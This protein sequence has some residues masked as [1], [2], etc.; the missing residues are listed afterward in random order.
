MTPFLLTLLV[1]LL[2]AGGLTL[3]YRDYRPR[4][5]RAV[6]LTV[7]TG[8]I[9]ASYVMWVSGGELKRIDASQVS[10]SGLR[11]IETAGSFRLEGQ[12]HNHSTTHRISTLPVRL[13]VEDCNSAGVCRPVHDETAEVTI[14]ISPDA[15]AGLRH[16]YVARAQVAAAGGDPAATPLQRRWRVGH[17]APRASLAP[18]R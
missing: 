3:I 7:A 11:M 1:A 9:V 6:E 17:G 5:R 18:V 4:F 16:V 10:L 8:L 15:S 14:S 2:V 12:A 13:L